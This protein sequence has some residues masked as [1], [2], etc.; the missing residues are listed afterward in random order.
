MTASA[1]PR[2]SINGGKEAAGTDIVAV[3]SATDELGSIVD[4]DLLTRRVV[5]LARERL[6]FERVG[7]YLCDLVVGSIFMRG[8]WGTGPDGKTT[9]ERRVYHEVSRADYEELSALH[10][11]GG[12]FVYRERMPL[13]AHEPKQTRVIEHGWLAV[14]P[15][16][17]ARRVVGVLYNDAAFSHSAVNEGKQAQLAAYATIVAGFLHDIPGSSV[18]ATERSTATPRHAAVQ[19]ALEVL[20]SNPAISGDL[21][22]NELGLSPGHLARLFKFEMGISLVEHRN[23][24]RLARFAAVL[25]QGRKNLLAAALEAGFGSYSQFH[26]VYSKL[27]GSTPRET[28]TRRRPGHRLKARNRAR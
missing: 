14:T 8:T 23:R 24:L 20:Q 17:F 1:T 4:P 7:L 9:D 10:S 3:L 26:R 16:V 27:V 12:F 13:V 22:A 18:Q 28:L 11:Q 25:Q 19:R 5:E 2:G 6:G 21:I 15:L